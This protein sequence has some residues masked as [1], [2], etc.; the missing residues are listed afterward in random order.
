MRLTALRTSD[1]S[2]GV[3][4]S[5]P[6][7]SNRLTPEIK[8]SSER[9]VPLLFIGLFRSFLFTRISFGRRDLGAQLTSITQKPRDRTQCSTNE[10][11][12][13][14][15]SPK[16][17]GGGDQEQRRSDEPETFHR[18]SLHIHR[19]RRFQSVRRIALLAV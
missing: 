12:R 7:G 10:C 14:I 16:K 5:E 19:H 3:A 17:N 11:G 8:S 18:R 4:V 6:A 2:E 15:V 13:Q 1:S 9:I